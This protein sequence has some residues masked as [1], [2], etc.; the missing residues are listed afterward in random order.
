MMQE[1]DGD[2]NLGI[3][4]QFVIFEREQGGARARSRRRA[5]ST[6]S[7]LPQLWKCDKC[8]FINQSSECGDICEICNS[9]RTHDSSPSSSSQDSVPGLT[10][11]SCS[12]Y[13]LYC[14]RWD[15]Q[16]TDTIGDRHYI[17]CY[18]TQSFNKSRVRTVRVKGNQI[19]SSTLW[20]LG[21]PKMYLGT[22]CYNILILH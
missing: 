2:G 12:A 14:P 5:P 9:E 7:T 3:R 6:S 10:R 17:R 22:L 1:R 18:C 13:R 4:V 15:H 21:I 20:I 8:T 16:K 11:V 19:H